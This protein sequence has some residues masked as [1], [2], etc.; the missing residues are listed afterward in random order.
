V[1]V[2]VEVEVEAE[3][4]TESKVQRKGP[5]VGILG[6]ENNRSINLYN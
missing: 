6:K 4:E 1:V 2:V 5:M 3:V